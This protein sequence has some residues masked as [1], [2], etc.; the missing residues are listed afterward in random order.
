MKGWARAFRSNQRLKK[1]GNYLGVE[2]PDD[3]GSML[4]VFRSVSVT[5]RLLASC[6]A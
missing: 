1:A 5:K 4:L 3:E 2:I 6:I